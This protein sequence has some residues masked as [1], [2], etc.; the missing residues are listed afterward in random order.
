MSGHSK[1][2]SIRHKKGATDAK[3]GK[4]FSKLIKELMGSS[5]EVA[6]D[7]QRQRPDSSEVYRLCCDNNKNFSLT[8]FEPGYT[9]RQGLQETIE[10]FSDA[11][12]IKKYK[13]EIYNV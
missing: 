4:I 7:K 10:W 1:W 6:A 12:N 9:L 13:S 3:R 11:N 2:H 8:G 5:I